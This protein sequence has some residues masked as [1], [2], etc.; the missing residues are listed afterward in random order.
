MFSLL[1]LGVR[2]GNRQWNATELIVGRS[3]ATHPARGSVVDCPPLPEVQGQI[4]LS[5]LISL[6]NVL[7]ARMSC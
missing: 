5:S 2:C 7:H 3:V 1:W 4:Q 6:F